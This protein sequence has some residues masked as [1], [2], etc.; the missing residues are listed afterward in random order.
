MD[1]SQF[2]N[3]IELIAFFQNDKNLALDYLEG[4]RWEGSPECPHCGSDKYYKFKN[5]RTYKCGNN[6]CYKKYTVTVGTIF[7]NSKIPLYKWFAA[8][9]V[10]TAHKKGISSHQ[11]GR[12]L[13]ISQKSCTSVIRGHCRS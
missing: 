3:H 1:F 12:D 9:Y 2:K 11:L 7:E 13:S 8:I 6:K 4:L 5:S 10:C